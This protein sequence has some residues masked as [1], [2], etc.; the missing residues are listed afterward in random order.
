MLPAG[1]L[2][3]A[4][5]L[6]TVTS[7]AGCS[8]A[9]Y[10]W[11]A[12][13]GQF[14]LMARRVPIRELLADPATPEPLRHQLRL[15]TE[16]REFASARLA[17]PDNQSYR[18]YAD[19][20]RP[21]VIWNVFA[22]PRFDTAPDQWCFPVAGCVN[23]RGYFSEAAA[24]AQAARLAAEGTD[25]YVGGVPAYSTLGWLNDPVLSSF[26]RWPEL[27]LARLIFHELGHQVAY[28]A[29]D[30]AF[31]E[32]FA[33]AVEEEGVQRWMEAHPERALQIDW[34]AAQTHRTQ[35]VALVL[36]A[37]SDLQGLYFAGLTPDE[38]ARDKQA[39]LAQLLQDYAALRARWGG[40]AGYDHWFR[41]PVNNAQ[42]ASVALYTQGVPAFRALLHS[43]HDQLP[44]F[45]ARVRAL[46]RMPADARTAAL[47]D[48]LSAAAGS[49]AGS[50]SVSIR[51]SPA[52]VALPASAA[53]TPPDPVPAI[54]PPRSAPG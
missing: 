27:E 54:L 22:A 28:A 41:Q 23:Y 15:A 53:G 26:V 48:V 24:R 8:T 4:L 16:L 2:R 6:A 9:G 37:R 18:S 17:L 34:Q 45:Y 39:R 31:N 51:R 43:E 35:F 42:L 46:A 44:A 3:T 50:P 11:Q 12:A 36:N 1:M 13:R 32:S 30:T 5:L 7:L 10:Y 20:Q 21:Y 47:A 14:D 38:T 29:G 19:L 52:A 40:Y 33:T 25:V 49:A